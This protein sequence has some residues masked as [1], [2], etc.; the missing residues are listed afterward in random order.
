MAATALV[1]VE[2]AQTIKDEVERFLAHEGIT[3]SEAFRIFLER[4]AQE[5]A[6]PTEV[7]RPNAE[8]IEAM[9]Q[10]RRGD[11]PSFNSVEELMA[12]LNAE[13]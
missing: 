5:Q 4:T 6:I 1:Q 9:Q 11:M 2:V 12:H 3:L 7:F 13:D 10:A 8:T